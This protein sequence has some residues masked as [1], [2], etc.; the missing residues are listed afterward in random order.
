MIST[1]SWE[2]LDP[3]LPV[4]VT[5]TQL[6]SKYYRRRRRRDISKAPKRKRA[7]P[8][9]P[10]RGQFPPTLPPLTAPERARAGDLEWFGE[11]KFF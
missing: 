3:F 2:V 8:L 5:I 6:F 9:P 7:R 11:D 4:T 10:I 1:K